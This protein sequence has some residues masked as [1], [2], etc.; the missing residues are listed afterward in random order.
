MKN[1][2]FIYT[3]VSELEYMLSFLG[4]IDAE[5][6][7]GITPIKLMGKSKMYFLIFER[8]ILNFQLIR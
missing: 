4:L 7:R 8:S 2:N 5:L 3:K 6:N 1:I